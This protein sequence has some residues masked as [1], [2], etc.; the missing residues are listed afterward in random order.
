M[1]EQLTDQGL[2]LAESMVA[3]HQ[4][5]KKKKNSHSEMEGEF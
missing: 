4:V 3:A 2:S 1:S 5:S